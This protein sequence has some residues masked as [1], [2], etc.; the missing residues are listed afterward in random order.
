MKNIQSFNL[1]LLP[2][3]LAMLSACSS[4]PTKP[5]WLNKP[6][7]KHPKSR[8]LAS[9][10]QGDNSNDADSRALAGLARNFEV[11]IKDSSMDFSKALVIHSKEQRQITNE[12]NVTRTL[13]AFSSKVLEGASID[14]RW[15]SG[16]GEHHS[17]A[18][19]N[20]QE[21][22][23]RFRGRLQ[24]MDKDTRFLLAQSNSAPNL[25]VSLS[26][27]ERAR[28][29]QLERLQID[30][31]LSVVARSGKLTRYDEPYFRNRIYQILSKQSFHIQA[32]QGPL[33]TQLQ[34]AVNQVGSKVSENALYSLHGKLDM[35][36]VSKQKG[37]FW[38]RGALELSVQYQGKV[39]AKQRI[40]LKES[41]VQE[42]M[43]QTRMLDKLTKKMGN[44][45]YTL[46]TSAEVKD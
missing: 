37:W 41:S 24:T 30:R 8:Y 46:L 33:I 4:A 14:E 26:A 6:Y 17:L 10:A 21:A 28:K 23:R 25:V 3:V 13:N 43:I 29:L 22:A 18:V 34:S 27:L 40:A 2:A 35:N 36:E 38:L 5:N 7:D 42:D 16:Q 11:A 32:E 44:Y 20:K 9:V 19:L 45:F 15:K 1:F 12:T 31:N 39:I